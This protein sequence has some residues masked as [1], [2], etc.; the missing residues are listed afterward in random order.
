[1]ILKKEGGTY[2]ACFSLLEALDLGERRDVR[3]CAA[4]AG[5]KTTLLKRLAS[6]YKERGIPAVVTT[7]TRMYAEDDPR[8]LLEPSPVKMREILERE[9]VVFLGKKDRNGKMKAP[10]KEWMQDILDLPFPV[11]IEADGSRRLPVKVPGE[12]EPVFPEETTHVV[13][14]Y[15]M[16]ALGRSLEEICFRPE[17][18]AALLG[19]RKESL[20]E[21]ADIA[22]LAGHPLGGR[23]SVRDAWPF[24]V[25]L[26]QADRP[27]RLEAAERIGLLTGEQVLIC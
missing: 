23:K 8:F 12:A 11:L 22:R 14:V 19:R 25:A 27:G 10:E 1:M 4:G 7:T 24:T 16:S 17:R 3:V 6:E 21:E 15:G 2:R 20:V 13:Y 9:G 26:T 18:A 5:G